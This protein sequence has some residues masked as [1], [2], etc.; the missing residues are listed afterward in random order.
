MLT[1]ILA[2]KPD[3]LTP[4]PGGGLKE[5]QG[6]TKTRGQVGDCIEYDVATFR[7]AFLAVRAGRN[8]ILIVNGISQQPRF[9]HDR[10]DPSQAFRLAGTNPVLS[11][12][13]AFTDALA[14]SANFFGGRIVGTNGHGVNSFDGFQGA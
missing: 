7:V 6:N 14:M 9:P 3:S 13:P 12:T 4:W 5:T 11:L 2:Q 1:A 8:L 10:H